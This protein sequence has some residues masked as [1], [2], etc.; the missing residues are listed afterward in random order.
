[1]MEVLI[2]ES[3]ELRI[4][5][6]V[7]YVK[8]ITKAAENM[9]YVQSNITAHIKKLETELNTTLL[10]RNNKGVTL[11][12]DGERLLLQAEKIISLLDETSRS[13]K[14]SEK[15][16]KIGATQTAAGYL[17]PQCLMKYKN[18]FPDVSISVYTLNQNILSAQLGK[19]QLDCLI[20]N[21]SQDIIQGKQVF[22]YPEELLLIAP[23]S[24]QY[25]DEVLRY[26]IITNGIE[27][28]PYRK[29][30]LNWWYLHQSNLPDIIE[31]DTVEA[32]LNLVAN[33]GGFSL[34][35][36]NVLCGRQDIRTFII[37]ELQST[38]IHMWVA[39]DKHPSEYTALKDILEE[40]LESG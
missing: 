28:C 24:C 32:I 34:L 30:L 39:K 9:G 1:M 33:G 37:E 25:L 15:S 17:L 13:F 31:L 8:S 21:R 16:L 12:H 6:E 40:E 11:T 5:R 14:S 18:K 4:F 22:Q 29:I 3:L 27:S 35:P 7:A 38:S 26:P 10:I 19:G 36:K 20:T 23:I 2:V